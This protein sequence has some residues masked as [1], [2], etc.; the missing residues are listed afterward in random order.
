MLVVIV[1]SQVV[2][3]ATQLV[4]GVTQILGAHVLPVVAVMAQ[5][6]VWPELQLVVPAM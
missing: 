3:G 2:I 6:D 4:V 1:V 5:L